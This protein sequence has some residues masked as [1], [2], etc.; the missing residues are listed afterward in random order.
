MNDFDEKE[1]TVLLLKNIEEYVKNVNPMLFVKVENA[2]IGGFITE[3]KHNVWFHRI[4]LK[5][6]LSKKFYETLNNNKE[7]PFLRFYSKFE[8]ENKEKIQSICQDLATQSMDLAGK[9]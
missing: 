4:C 1:M 8:H 3:R 2:N 5:N 6:Y 9:Q 7:T